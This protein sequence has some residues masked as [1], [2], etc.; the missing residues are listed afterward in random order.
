MIIGL[1]VGGTHTDVVLLG[2]EG[3]IREYKV[4]TDP[5]DLFS[6]VLAGIEHIV[7]GIEPDRINRVVLST[8]LTTNAIVQEKYPEVGMIVSGGPGIDPEHFRTNRHY[9]SITGSI[10]HRGR[11]VA[12]VNLDEIHEIAAA[13]KK[14]GIRNVGIVGKFSV[15]NPAHE[16]AVYH[17]I[18]DDFGKI[19]LG[20]HVSGN[21]NFPRRIATTFL[22]TTIRPIHKKFFAAVKQSLE[23]KGLMIPIHLLKADGGTMSFEASLD[24]PGQTIL[25]GPSASVMGAIAFASETEETLVLDIGGTT[26]DMAILVD[27]A[28]LLDPVGITLSQNRK[29]IQTL[30]RS[31]ETRSIGIGGDSAV[32]LQDGILTV[33][34]DREGPAMAYGGKVPTPTDAFFVLGIQKGDGLAASTAG[35]APIAQA[36]GISVEAAAD[37]IFD[38]ACNV[39]LSQAG[40]MIDA[41]NSKPVYTVHELQEGLQVHPKRILVLGGPAP[42]FADRLRTLSDFDVRAVPHWSVANAIG[43]ALAR[44]TCEVTLFGDTQREIVSAPEEDFSEP[45]NRNF[46]KENAVEKAFVLLRDKAVRIGAD[47]RD[48][49]MEVT[50]DLQFNM[51]RG[52]YTA[53]R[54]IRVKVQV[55]PGLIH[56]YQAII[57]RLL[58]NA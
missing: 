53:G 57:E 6:T 38:E 37:R 11:E 13:L 12:P 14:E 21:L 25:S 42:E 10:D 22:N 8:T 54:N 19:F 1:D 15:R 16:L 33:G 34:P 28:P 31:L 36:L 32:R 41:I 47:T 9:Y 56:G 2:E 23:Q 45:V 18:K 39:I 58:S 24:F 51:V 17:A 49:E 44:T 43:A 7:E 26:T 3:L 35:I 30:I 20:H 29:R 4:R 27:R 5:E 55:K 46:S 48:L 50:E 40:Q 52:F